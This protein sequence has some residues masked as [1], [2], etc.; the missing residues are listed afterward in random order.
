MR[1]AID[2]DN[3]ITAFAAAEQVPGGLEQF[4]S[5]KEL[6]KLVTTWPADRLVETWNSFAGMAGFGA[7]LKPVKKFTS[8][9]T[10]VARIWKVIQKLDGGTPELATAETATSA[11]RAAKGAPKRA[12]AVKA[13]A[14]KA[15]APTAREGSKKA[16]IMGMLGKGATLQE[17]MGAAGWQAHSVRGF[18]STAAKKEGTRIESTRNKEGRRFYKISK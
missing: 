6:A 15:G 1:F 13:T 11:P 8:R 3:V 12:K 9:K 5:E 18:L 4:V 17:L 10:A 16:I 2:N 14:T 7:D